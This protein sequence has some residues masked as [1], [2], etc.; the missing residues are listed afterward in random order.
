M[1]QFFAGLITMA[2]TLSAGATQSA[3]EVDRWLSQLKAPPTST[4]P[5]LESES[6]AALRGILQAHKNREELFQFPPSTDEP[7]MLVT[8]FLGNPR[9]A[10]RGEI[11]ARGVAR[12]HREVHDHAFQSGHN[13]T[14]LDAVQLQEL[15]AMLQRLPSESIGVPR[16]EMVV[17]SFADSKGSWQTRIYDKRSVPVPVT[18]L[19]WIL[20]ALPPGMGSPSAPGGR[21][22]SPGGVSAQLNKNSYRR[23]EPIELSVSATGEFVTV[24]LGLVVETR[25][26]VPHSRLG[27]RVIGRRAMRAA[28][29]VDASPWTV[30]HDLEALFAWDALEKDKRR[31]VT[32]RVSVTPRNG[33]PTVTLELP[34]TFDYGNGR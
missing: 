34:M 12:D 13:Y 9:I 30:R 20:G 19:F 2:L 10:I 15:R 31:D 23:G 32:L 11:S 3:P 24:D 14:S 26:G 1:R 22:V 18:E 16:D 5:S 7:V 21:T 17:V 27:E 29:G 4:L 33:A 28:N 25:E 6:S 8:Y